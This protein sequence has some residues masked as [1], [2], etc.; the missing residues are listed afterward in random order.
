MAPKTWAAT[1]QPVRKHPACCRHCQEAFEPGEVRLSSALDRSSRS[2]FHHPKCVEG[3][4]GQLAEV[5]GLLALPLPAQAVLA[6]FA[7]E[8][9]A[10]GRS[11]SAGAAAPD[12]E[13]PR[14]RNVAPARS[15][16]PRAEA[17]EAPDDAAQGALAG[18]G[19]FATEELRHLSW[20]GDVDY[21]EGRREQIPT[22]ARVPEHLASAVADARAAVLLAL[23][24]AGRGSADEA[25]LWKL[26]SFVDRLL[27]AAP[28]RRGGAKHKTLATKVSET[29]SLRLRLLWRGDWGALWS[30]ALACKPPRSQLTLASTPA[31]D[32]KQVEALLLEG[33]LGRA[34][35][36]ARGRQ[37]LQTG[38]AALE[39]LR[40]K[41]PAEDAMALDAVPQPP[42]TCTPE[43]RAALEAQVQQGIRHFP[44][45]SGPGPL[46]S[47]FEHW[48]SLS[49]RQDGLAAAGVVLTRWLLGEAP[50]AAL[51]AHA[52]GRLLAL[53]KAGGGT[54]PLV[55]GSVVRRLAAKAAAQAA[56]SE[57]RA[58]SGPHQHGVS[59]SAGAELLHKKLTALADV[60]PGHVFV[61][62]DAENAFNAVSRAEVLKRISVGVPGLS[63]A[64]ATLYGQPTT[65]YWTDSDGQAHQVRAE[66]GV[67]QGC[68]LS[69]GL[70]A[71]ALAPALASLNARLRQLCPTAV[72]LAYLDDLHVVCAANCAEAAV[73]FAAEDL[74][75]VGCSLN[76]AKTRCWCPQSLTGLPATLEASRVPSLPCLG[77][78]LSDRGTKAGDDPLALAVGADPG[79]FAA[80]TAALQSLLGRLREQGRPT[81]AKLPGFAQSLCCWLSAAPTARHARSCR[82]VLYVRRPPVRLLGGARRHEPYAATEGAACIAS[83]QG[84]LCLQ[85]C[86]ATQGSRVLGVVGAVRCRSAD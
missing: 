86:R 29:L 40:A 80:A 2:Y 42:P 52:A 62:L 31:Q 11:L 79:P 60:R 16:S 12:R 15:R 78:V 45:I 24:S 61:S 54:R 71:V 32:T 63:L 35:S 36:T 8:A 49:L 30:G 66:R 37:R 28:R 6:T 27:F 18:E 82:L 68:P 9:V 59:T 53:E 84:R 55:C 21:R 7:D 23:A 81:Q 67:D 5:R 73:S 1:V 64:A 14:R 19:P 33:E 58:T 83:P 22:L 4:V 3:G 39:A 48:A 17:A 56:A 70:F 43:Q 47:R 85:L 44:R 75:K 69:P 50:D 20:W 57:L 46:G 72:V 74:A 77:S 51:R 76:L 25:R 13:R 41:F 10:A 65:H 26:L 38:A 34:L